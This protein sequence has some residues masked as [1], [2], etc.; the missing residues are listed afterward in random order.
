MISAK[1]NFKNNSPIVLLKNAGRSFEKKEVLLN[2]N[3]S[4]FKGEMVGITGPNGGGKSTLLLLI[5]GLLRPTVGKI[6]ILGIE[7]HALSLTAVGSVGLVT[8]RP[9]L[10][11]LLTGRENLRY[12]AN[13]FG[14]SSDQADEKSAPL[15][16]S[17]ALQPYVDKRVSELSTGTQQK[18]S[19][20]RALMLS[21]VLLLL[22]EPTANLDPI[23]SQAFFA[24][25]R[26]RV[27]D[28]LTCLLVTHD[29][30]AAESLCD[31]VIIVNREI[32]KEMTFSNTR[33]CSTGPLFAAWKEVLTE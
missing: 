27:N 13:L 25:V 22:D 6:T 28:G 30:P 15:L 11:P 32:K 18:L 8:A 21:P 16:N 12:F 4:I 14:I 29:L 17:F 33:V 3:L 2:I 26:K 9:G 24:E 10:Y 23:A 5:S 20:I 31:R 7:A 19:L 1:R